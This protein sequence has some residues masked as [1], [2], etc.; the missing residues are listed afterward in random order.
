MANGVEDV[1]EL[2]CE[3]E[4][5]QVVAVELADGAAAVAREILQPLSHPPPSILPL[6]RQG[7]VKVTAYELDRLVP[8]VGIDVLHARQEQ[9]HSVDVHA[10]GTVVRRPDDAWHVEAEGLQ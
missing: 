1:E 10:D 8:Y 5:N 9:H 7:S 4:S 2:D 3:V 6:V